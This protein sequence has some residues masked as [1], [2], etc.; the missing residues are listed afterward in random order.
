MISHSYEIGDFIQCES[1]HYSWKEILYGKII[2]IFLGEPWTA[3]RYSVEFSCGK[4]GIV[5]TH[6][7]MIKITKEQ[8][9][10]HLLEE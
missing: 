10:L 7:N 9:F 2:Y 8:Y 1:S 4:K 6:N 5:G 3:N